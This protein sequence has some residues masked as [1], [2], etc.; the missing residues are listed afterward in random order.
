MIAPLKR[1]THKKTIKLLPQEKE[2][3]YQF[4]GKF[5]ATRNAINMFGEAVI[6]AAHITLLK[7]VKRKGGLDYL[8]VF[9][10]DSEKLWFIDDVSHVTCLL[11]KDY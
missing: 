9:E 5:V 11:P 3:H 4:K 8:Q 6:V 10:I 2:G 7:E 1:Q